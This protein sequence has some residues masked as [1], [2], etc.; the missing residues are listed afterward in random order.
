M[1]LNP[2]LEDTTLAALISSKICHDLA[3]QIGAI[4]NG[5]EL[6]EQENDADARYYALELIH[7]ACSDLGSRLFLRIREQL[8]LAYY[9]GSQNFA[10]LVPGY[11]AFYTG[12]EPSKAELVEQKHVDKVTV[13]FDEAVRKDFLSR[14]QELRPGSEVRARIDCGKTRLS[15]YLLRKVVQVWYE[16]VLFRWPF[17]H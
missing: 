17:L 11:F 4:N 16:S 14:N 12:T 6:L 8:G 5:L 7:E 2:V 13:G 10:G 3:G 9:C 1:A 15:Y